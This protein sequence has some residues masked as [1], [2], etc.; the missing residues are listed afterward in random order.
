MKRLIGATMASVISL[1]LILGLS[2][3]SVAAQ[4][5]C[6]LTVEPAEAPAGDQFVL[7]G[8][9]YTPEKLSLQRGGGEPVTFDLSLGDADPFEIPIGSKTGDEGLWQAVAFD[10]DTGCNARAHFRVT[11]KQTDMIDD[12]LAA[13]AAGL[14]AIVY[15]IVVIGGFGAGTLVARY[16]RARA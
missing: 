8:S 9:G 3:A 13:P 10:E 14:P 12:L 6:V 15:L 16:A 11:L 5:E 1:G 7:S 4:D 2:V